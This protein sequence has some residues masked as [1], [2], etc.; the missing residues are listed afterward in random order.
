MSPDDPRAQACR[1][2]V[3]AALQ[4]TTGTKLLLTAGRGTVAGVVRA[5]MEAR[6]AMAECDRLAV[7]RW[8]S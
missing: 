5:R 3:Y 2:A 1:A 6:A 4:R 8:H 7:N